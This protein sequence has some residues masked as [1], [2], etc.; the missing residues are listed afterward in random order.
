MVKRTGY[1]DQRFVIYSIIKTTLEMKL[2][3]NVPSVFSRFMAVIAFCFISAIAWTQD[4]GLD[5]D[6]DLDKGGDWYANPIVWV[7]A[8]AVFILL[9]VALLRGGSKDT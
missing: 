6:V 3:Q 4:Q 2:S 5:V 8:G 9:L 1:K 7:I